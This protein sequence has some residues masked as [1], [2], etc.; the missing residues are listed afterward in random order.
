MGEVWNFENGIATTYHYFC[1]DSTANSNFI[2]KASN[3]ILID[4]LPT[5]ENLTPILRESQCAAGGA[6]RQLDDVSVLAVWLSSESATKHRINW[7]L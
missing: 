3:F 1:I 5:A 2:L 6:A 4:V 7:R